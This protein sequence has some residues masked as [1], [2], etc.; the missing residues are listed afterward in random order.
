[1]ITGVQIH[2]LLHSIKALP[3]LGIYAPQCTALSPPPRPPPN[4]L[5][6]PPNNRQHLVFFVNQN[7][8]KDIG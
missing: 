1:M 3:E 6:R 8:L 2:Q 5:L 4:Q 7:S